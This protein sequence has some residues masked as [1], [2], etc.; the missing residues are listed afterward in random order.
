MMDDVWGI[1]LN[2]NNPKRIIPIENNPYKSLKIPDK[3]DPYKSLDEESLV[4]RSTKVMKRQ[5]I[6]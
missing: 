2:P 1:P 6:G 4:V 3:R 5:I